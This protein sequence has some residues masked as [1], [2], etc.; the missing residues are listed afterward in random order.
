VTPRQIARFLKDVLV[1]GTYAIGGGAIFGSVII[2][3]LPF[4][5]LATNLRAFPIAIIRSPRGG[6]DPKHQDILRL[7]C[8]IDIAVR[9]LDT[10]G[11]GRLIG[12]A[13][14][15]GVLDVEREC[16][17]TIGRRSRNNGFSILGRIDGFDRSPINAM[18]L[19][20]RTISFDC[21]GT[22]T[23]F[24]EAASSVSAV[25]LT[26]GDARI[27]WIDPPARFDL[28]GVRI[29]RAAGAVPPETNADGV[30]VAD[31]ALGVETA[32]NLG[33]GAGEFSYTV[34]GH[35]DDDGDAVNDTVSGRGPASSDT[36]TVT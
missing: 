5:R 25:D 6:T 29:R 35:Y 21:I 13:T 34:F 33:V 27:T 26:G 12:T 7:A 22:A 24:Y 16:A 3:D 9:V 23:D 28:G 1:N 20:A 36:V 15:N 10:D 30:L 8:S 32:D 17:A 4:E 2:S 14:E 11:E 31:V 19:A 18:R